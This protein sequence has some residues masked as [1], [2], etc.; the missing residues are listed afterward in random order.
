MRSHSSW[1]RTT[2]AF[3][4]GLAGASALSAQPHLVV[5]LNR[6]SARVDFP[7][8]FS[9]E[10]SVEHD[11]AR[12]F[13]GHDPQHGDEIWRTDGTP[14]GTSRLVDLCPGSC[15]SESEPLTFFHGSLY[16]LGDD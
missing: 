5:D 3:L 4:L 10:G 7:F 11:G 2:G 9:L 14:D 13:I 15:G 12:Y 16:F 1:R 8:P 6:Q